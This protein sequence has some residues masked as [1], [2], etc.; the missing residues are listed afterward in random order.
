LLIK[1]LIIKYVQITLRHDLSETPF[2]YLGAEKR[3]TSLIPLSSAIN[4]P[5]KGF[6][7]RLDKKSSL[8]IVDY[9]TGKGDMIFRDIESLFDS[10]YNKRNRV[11]FQ[12]FLYSLLLDYS[13]NLIAEPYFIRELAKNKI[14]RLFIDNNE[15][16]EFRSML[17]KL[18]EE[19]F[20]PEVPFTAT[21]NRDICEW[22]DF[23]SI[24][25]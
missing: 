5:L 19:I 21:A 3:L 25:Y 11:A 12:M 15:K 22:C 10:S 9:K 4:V 23:N 20:N 14:H 2:D 6:L 7:D 17:I 16:E 13:G 1:R 8:R 24:C 18:L